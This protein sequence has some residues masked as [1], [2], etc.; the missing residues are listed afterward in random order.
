[1]NKLRFGHPWN[2]MLQG[3]RNELKNVAELLMKMASRVK[4]EAPAPPK[5]EAQA[6][7][8]KKKKAVLKGIHGHQ[9]R[10]DLHVTHLPEVKTLWPRRQPQYP[11]ESAPGSNKLDSCLPPSHFP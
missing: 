8:L 9:K 6:K 1:M 10:I 2:Y 3:K 7:A 4:E 5:A 11:G